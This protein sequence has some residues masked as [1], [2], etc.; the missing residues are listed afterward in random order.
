MTTVTDDGVDWYQ[1]IAI[2]NTEYPIDTIAVGTGSGSE[3]VNSDGLD[4]PVY[5]GQAGDD[6]NVTFQTLDQTGLMEAIITVRGGTEV[7]AGTV[8]TEMAVVVNGDDVVVA[9]D[10]FTPIEVEA[11]HTEEFT[12]PF[13]I[14]GT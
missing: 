1:D 13:Q 6:S 5:E 3:G 12:M 7:P 14:T 10:N 4:A 8:I 2:G 9:V 11:G